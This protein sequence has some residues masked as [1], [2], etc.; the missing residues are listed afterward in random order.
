MTRFAYE[1]EAERY[2]DMTGEDFG[3]EEE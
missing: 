1:E 2:F 3:D